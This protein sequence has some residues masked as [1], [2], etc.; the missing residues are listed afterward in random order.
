MKQKLSF[1]DAANGILKMIN[2]GE[3]FVVN[4][5]DFDKFTNLPITKHDT[6]PHVCDFIK[7][8]AAKELIAYYFAYLVASP[9]YEIT[10]LKTNAVLHTEAE[11]NF[12]ERYT[13][14]KI[15]ERFW[16]K[17]MVCRNQRIEE[18]KNEQKM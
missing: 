18:A 12:R 11:P 16:A 8:G 2:A 6:Y 1:D 4:E 9:G 3:D 5:Y 15:E 13:A 14:E 10:S 7:A 17:A